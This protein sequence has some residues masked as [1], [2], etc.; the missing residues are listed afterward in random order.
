MVSGN[1]E[2]GG[3]SSRYTYGRCLEGYRGIAV[4]RWGFQLAT[5]DPSYLVR[6]QASL[7]PGRSHLSPE[8]L[9]T[10]APAGAPGGAVAASAMSRAPLQGSAAPLAMNA[11][12]QLGTGSSAAPLEALWDASEP[13]LWLGSALVI[14]SPALHAG[15]ADGDLH[16]T[17]QP[18]PGRHGTNRFALPEPPAASRGT[19]FPPP[20]PAGNGAAAGGLCAAL[21][22]RSL[23]GGWRL[24]PV[25]CQVLQRQ[26]LQRWGGRSE[27][28]SLRPSADTSHPRA[29]GRRRDLYALAEGYR[30]R[31]RREPTEA[32]QRQ[33]FVKERLIG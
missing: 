7:T 12:C 28:G 13:R 33:H 3:L 18:G 14:L 4:I 27:P 10:A 20:F 21:G 29:A 19:L 25:R 1:G 5:E 9:G 6:H 31:A 2:A 11:L 32:V 8:P 22:G 17:R 24:P 30:C 15:T 26:V 23:P 16:Y